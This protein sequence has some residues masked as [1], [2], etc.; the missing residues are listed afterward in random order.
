MPVRRKLRRP[1]TRDCR[2]IR[3]QPVFA[4]DAACV[5][6]PDGSGLV[7]LY[8]DRKTRT[9]QLQIGFVSYPEAKFR[10]ITRDINSY[11]G[12]SVSRDGKT[13]TTVQKEQSFKLY[14]MPSR[15]KSEEHA[16][17]ITPRGAAYL[18]AWADDKNL[19]LGDYDSHKYYRI[20]VRGKEKLS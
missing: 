14:I 13:L 11:V 5:W 2:S 4:E 8:S 18:F 7:V 15:E 1:R 10:A 6:L 19:I 20:G 16:T 9:A 3:E 12:L 17:A